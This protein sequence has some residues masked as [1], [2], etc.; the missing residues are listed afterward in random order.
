MDLVKNY[1]E[2]ESAHFTCAPN[3]IFISYKF[4]KLRTEESTWLQLC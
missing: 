2:A 3:A 4:G 1:R